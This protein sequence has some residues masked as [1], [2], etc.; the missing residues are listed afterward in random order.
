[1]D[2]KKITLHL[3]RDSTAKGED[4]DL[5]LREVWGRLL[6]HK[7]LIL[8]VVLCGLSL[9]W[10]VLQQLVP[11]YVATAMVLIEP[12]ESNIVNIEA[13]VQGVSTDPES[14]HGEILVLQSRELA[15]KALKVMGVYDNPDGSVPP[16]AQR[17]LLDHLNPLTYL[18]ADWRRGLEGLF[19]DQPKPVAAPSNPDQARQNAMVG[20]FLSHLSVRS[21]TGTRV[22]NIS[23][24]A[25]DPALAAK[26]ANALAEAYVR[27]TLDVKFAG[28]REANAWL[29]ER[30]AELRLKV[31]DSEEAVERLRNGEALIEGRS[32][33]VVTDQIAAVNAE[34]IVAKSEIAQ[35]Q[36]KLAQIARLRNDPGGL[37]TSSEVLNS[38]LIQNLR[39]EQF[40]L[41]RR[42]AELSTEYGEKHPRMI[43]IHAE[44]DNLQGK[45]DGEIEKIVSGIRND[46]AVAEARRD[47]LQQTLNR[48]TTEVGSL[49]K[50]ESQLS[51]LEREAEANRQLFETF[52]SR[53]KETTIQEK[54]QQPDA[55]IISEAQ[56]PFAPAFPPKRAI[57]FGSLVAS[58]LLGLSLVLLFELVDK[59]FR[60]VKQLEAKTGLQ[61]I[62][63]VPQLSEKLAKGQAPYDYLVSNPESRYGEALRLLHANLLWA[64]SG[65]KRPRSILVT[66][67]V[68]GEGKTSTTL[69]LARRAAFLNQKVLIVDGDLRNPSAAKGLGLASTPGLSEVL[70]GESTLEEALQLDEP[71]GAAFLGTGTV[72]YDPVSL[73]QSRAMRKFMEEA[74]QKFDLVIIDTSPVLAVTEPRILARMV[75]RNVFVVRWGKTPRP[76]A[77]EALK[78]LM[79]FGVMIDGLVLSQIDVKQQSSYGYGEYGYYS[80]QMKGYYST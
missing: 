41:E 65:P 12:P 21:Q 64:R 6:H 17:G 78:Q 18:P 53:S 50:V 44:I 75:D 31:K 15:V 34:L 61:A 29:S 76:L 33:R 49:S 2:N 73:V 5:N 14:V 40:E 59:S 66:S 8:A 62:G 77:L 24:T 56:A 67:A 71:S 11:R 46:L 19:G 48:L 55:R 7:W 3:P 74:C 52:L 60:T 37:E 54:L 43:N 26:A 28:T 39:Q 13:V 10:L 45:I 58:L 9:T 16:R 47:S 79:E 70:A 35:L 42:S 68:P 1:M 63:I 30:L 25:T 51:A 20:Y 4:L 57:L 38:A 27:H 23:F 80:S 36:A 69:A 22:V 32:A 72:K